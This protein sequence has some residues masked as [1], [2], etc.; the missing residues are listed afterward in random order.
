MGGTRRPE[1]NLPSAILDL[2]HLCHEAIERNREWAREH[3]YLVR[4]EQDP[5][6]TPV[7]LCG[8]WVLLE[9]SG[10]LSEIEPVL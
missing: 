7:R 5:A 10:G 4:Q 8:R 3:G 2:C 6:T 9:D 1:S